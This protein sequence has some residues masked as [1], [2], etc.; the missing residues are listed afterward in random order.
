[1]LVALVL[2]SVV[3][4]GRVMPGKEANLPSRKARKA[5]GKKNVKGRAGRVTS[6]PLYFPGH[7]ASN[8]MQR[9]PVNPNSSYSKLTDAPVN[10]SYAGSTSV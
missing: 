10:V 9:D 3:H 6:I 5:I 7:Q 8:G 4:P 2:L 1:M